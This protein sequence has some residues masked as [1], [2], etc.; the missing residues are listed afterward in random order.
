MSAKTAPLALLLPSR[1]DVKLSA[2]RA[3][4]TNE[5]EPVTS[6]FQ[7]LT[8]GVVIAVSITDE[9]ARNGVLQRITSAR[10]FL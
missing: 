7:P 4:P 1:S 9:V 3:N 8:N 6:N 10:G 2:S 5:P